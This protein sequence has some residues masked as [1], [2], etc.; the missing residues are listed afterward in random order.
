M[1]GIYIAFNFLDTYN[2]YIVYLC[3]WSLCGALCIFY[4]YDKISFQGRELLSQR[5]HFLKI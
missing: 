1:L 2:H 4:Y 3:A 5:T